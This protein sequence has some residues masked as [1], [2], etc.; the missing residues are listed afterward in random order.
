MYF[1]HSRPEHGDAETAGSR[2]QPEVGTGRKW[3]PPEVGA[4]GSGEAP[5]CQA[6]IGRLRKPAMGD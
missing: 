5:V 6:M 4:T 3:G 2:D 1:E